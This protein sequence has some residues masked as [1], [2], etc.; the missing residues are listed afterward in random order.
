[1]SRTVAHHMCCCCCCC[2][3]LRCGLV[4]RTTLT[5]R[6]SAG[7]TT[8]NITYDVCMWLCV[9]HRP[10]IP[11]RNK[12]TAAAAAAAALSGVAWCHALPRL[13]VPQQHLALVAAAAANHMTCEQDSCTSYVLLLLLL[14]QVWPGATHYPDSTSL[15][16]TWPWWQQQQ[17]QIT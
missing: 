16:K 9:T 8:Y 15:S 6:P 12:C 10:D 11:L 5:S 2:C 1:V 14:C 3:S 4:P 13:H 17:L 7:P